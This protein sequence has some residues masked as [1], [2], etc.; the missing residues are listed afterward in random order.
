MHARAQDIDADL[1]A[2]QVADGS[3][4]LMREQLEAAG[5]HTRQHRDR[6]AGIQ[7]KDDPCREEEAEI[8]LAAPDICVEG[9]RLR[10]HVADI[11]E[12]LRA[13]Q[14]LGDVPGRDADGGSRRSRI[15]VVSGGP[16]SASV[17]RAPR[18]PA[19]PAADS[20]GQEIAADLHDL[21][22]KSP[23]CISSEPPGESHGLS[24]AFSS[25][26]SSFR[27]RQSV[28]SA[29]S[30]FG[31]DLIMP[32]SWRRSAIEA[33]RV[34]PGRTRATARR[35]ARSASERVVVALSEP[36]I[37]Q[38]LRG[39]LRLGGADVVGFEKARRTR[40]VATGWSRTNSLFPTTM[41]QK[42]CDHGLSVVVLRIT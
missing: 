14:V 42:Y 41:Q 34:P 40:L 17:L 5:M 24:H 22:Q 25:R 32:T 27:K 10:G 29:M 12:P 21:H 19:A 28:P 33:Q 39:P 4:G 36:A 35:A 15:V 23:V 9:A 1:L 37:D 6:H 31:L 2:L 18:T 26:L 11:G 13:Q 16:S 3:N 8:E 38:L 30:A 7:A 20:A